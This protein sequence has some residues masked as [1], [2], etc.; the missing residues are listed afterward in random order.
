MKEV[1]VSTKATIVVEGMIWEVE[2]STTVEALTGKKFAERIKK[3]IGWLFQEGFRPT[4]Q[5]HPD[6]QV[7]ASSTNSAPMPEQKAIEDFIPKCPVCQISPMRKSSVQKEEDKIMWYCPR[8]NGGDY[9]KQRAS[10]DVLTGEVNHWE[11][12][13]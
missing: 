12:K 7:E 10:S 3:N 9:C 13:K 1:N 11:V 2:I 5:P 4:G 8:K 6:N